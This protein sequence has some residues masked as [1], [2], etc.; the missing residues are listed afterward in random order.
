[1]AKQIVWTKQAQK[2]RKEILTYW[3]N[4]YKSSLYSKKLNEIFK[5]WIL[6]LS[7]RPEIG[8]NTD[9]VN[10]KVK[11]VKDYLIFYQELN[12]TF[13]VLTIWDGRQ[14]PDKQEYKS[15]TKKV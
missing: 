13:F 4:R 2:D 12:E 7:K 10:V 15:I 9:I 1:M 6:L 14:N 8:R 3:I 5:N 11:V